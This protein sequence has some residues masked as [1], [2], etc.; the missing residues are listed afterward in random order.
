VHIDW[1]R[2]AGVRAAAVLGGV[3]LALA[4]LLFFKYSI[5]H[6]L[7]PPWLRVVTGVVVGLAAV[8][9]SEWRLRQDYATTADALAGGGIVV[10]YAS[11]WAASA[12][13]GLV[14]LTAGFVLMVAVTAACGALAWR[15]ASLVIALLGL[16][17]G[18]ATPLLVSSGNDRPIGLFGYILLLD[19]ALLVLAERRR[20][21]TLALLSLAGTLFYEILWVAVRMRSGQ[22]ALG[23]AIVGTFALVFAVAGRLAAAREGDEWRWTQSAAMVVP[24]AFVLYF[25]SSARFHLGLHL[26]AAWLVLL[27]AMAGWLARVQGPRAMALGAASASLAAIGVWVLRAR[28][29]A[30]GWQLAAWCCAI[31]AVFQFFVEREPDMADRD[32]PTPPA[33]LTAVGFF[34]VLVVASVRSAAIAPW[35]AG[36]AGLAALLVRHGGLAQ[37]EQLHWVAA[38]ASAIGSRCSGWHTKRRPARRRPRSSWR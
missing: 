17:G 1:E 28:P 7:F 2:F 5:E 21:P 13:Y 24:F 23:L 34:L 32:G 9:A 26:L 33:V 36:F 31:A 15:H 37:R 11:S 18:F 8:A 10:L 27:S 25:A 30:L 38:A 29:G 22:V 19:A 6:G 16:I 35:I 20:W 3:A 14:P 12:L 4:G